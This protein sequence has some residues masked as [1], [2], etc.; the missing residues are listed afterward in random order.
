MDEEELDNCVSV[1]V[2]VLMAGIVLAC[3]GHVCGWW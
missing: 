2:I 3:L 1:Y